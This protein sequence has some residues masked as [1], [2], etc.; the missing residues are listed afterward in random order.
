MHSGQLK[1]LNLCLPLRVEQRSE[2]AAARAGVLGD[3]TA[4][5]VAEALRH[6]S[7]LRGQLHYIQLLEGGRLSG[8]AIARLHGA[9]RRGDGGATAPTQVF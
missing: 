1:R 5:A 6:N 3:G 8:D 4:F 2:Q 7:H 9:V